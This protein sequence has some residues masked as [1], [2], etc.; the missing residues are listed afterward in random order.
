MEV[1]TF[2][3]ADVLG[4]L[5][6]IYG[7]QAEKKGLYLNIQIAP[8][9]PSLT[10]SRLYFREILQNFITNAIKYTEKGGVT[11]TGQA[12]DR[13]HIIISVADTGAGIS[14]SEQAKVYEKFW[15]SEDP[16]TRSTGGTGL[17]LFITAKL[18]HRIGAELKLQSKMQEG[19]TFSIILPVQ[20]V[21]SIDE[22][23]VVKN[24]V[25]RIFS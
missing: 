1:E 16:L 21:K 2:T 20:A 24:E 23:S 15:R 18:A 19:S 14:K 5:Q 6:E 17:G 11:V 3:V 12:M 9:T 7:P 8:S 13:D 25:A 22:A 4:G 10:T